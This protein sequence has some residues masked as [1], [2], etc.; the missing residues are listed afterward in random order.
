MGVQQMNRLTLPSVRGA[1]KSFHEALQHNADFSHA[2]S[3]LAKTYSIEWVLTARGDSELL[4]KAE[5]SA[6]FAIERNP[7]IAY[8]YKELGMAKL[9]LGSLT[10][11]SMRSRAE[12]LSPALR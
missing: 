10:R 11:A 2:F 3:G 5:E 6:R 1:R 7:E 4:R 12:E 8:G 9:Y